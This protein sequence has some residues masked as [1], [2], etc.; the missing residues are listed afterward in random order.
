[1]CSRKVMTLPGSPLS[2]KNVAFTFKYAWRLSGFP[3]G[4]DRF[5]RTCLQCRSVSASHSVVSDSLQPHGL[6]V[7][8][9]LLCPWNS[10]GKHTWVGCHFLLQAIFATQGLNLGLL[11]YR[12][13]LYHLSHK[14][15]QVQSLDWEDRLEKGMATH[16]SILSWRIQWTDSSRLHSMGLQRVG[17][18][19]ATNI[20]TFT[21]M[22]VLF[23]T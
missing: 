3:G 4:S 11:H 13:I 2:K 8:I 23:L 18:N 10:P 15:T 7:A 21:G 17:H 9:R 14:G 22:E 20:F 1:M 6:H 16:S 12:Q 19:W 5:F